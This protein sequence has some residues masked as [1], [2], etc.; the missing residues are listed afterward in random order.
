[1]LDEIRDLSSEE[2]S[3]GLL[4]SVYLQLR[5]RHD[6]GLDVSVGVLEDLNSDEI[7]HITGILQRQQGPVSEK[8]LRD[9][10]RIIKSEHS[11]A[12]VSTEDDLMALRNKF[13]ESKGMGK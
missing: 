11:A 10:V 2:F 7:S 9:C 5:R 4:G 3:S 6:Q 13:R 8:A 12:N 1:M